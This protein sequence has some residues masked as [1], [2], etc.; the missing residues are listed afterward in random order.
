MS[1]TTQLD[2]NDALHILPLADMPLKMGALKKTRLIKNGRLEGVVE[3]YSDTATGS[4]QVSPDDLTEVFD[5]SGDRAGDLDVVK[6][7]ADLPSYDVYSL[8]TG[9]AKANVDIENADA[10]KLSD[11]MVDSLTAQTRT[12]TRPLIEKV[13]GDGTAEERSLEDLC[14]LFEDHS[15]KRAHKNLSE[16]AAQLEIKLADMPRFLEDYADLYVSLA[17][18]QRCHEDAAAG[19]D[20]LMRDLE[21]L[22]NSQSIRNKPEAAKQVDSAVKTFRDLYLAIGNMLVALRVRTV[23][24]WEDISARRFRRIASLVSEHQEKIGA[25]LC[26]ITVKLA[27][28]RQYVA[29]AGT[30]SAIDRANFVSHSM[31]YALDTVSGFKFDDGW[32]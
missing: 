17:F 22:M 18:F 28:W 7:L 6:K 30:D 14:R 20:S 26:A 15:A 2:E 3:L 13:Y 5:F 1:N 11:K 27:A 24:M 25:M 32:E 12:F 8:R 9:L 4:G 21:A 16:L 29:S 23:V 19:F 31:M 10:L